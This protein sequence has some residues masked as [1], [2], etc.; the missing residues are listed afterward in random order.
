MINPKTYKESIKQVVD[1]TAGTS[2]IEMEELKDGR[3]LCL[4]FGYEEGY[5][6]G[7]DYQIRLG[8]SLLTL[9]AKLAVNIDDLQCDYDIDWRMPWDK[10][11]G[12]IC[13]TDMAVCKNDNFT[14]YEKEA[15][16]IKEGLD[17]GTLEVY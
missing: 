10:K 15:K 7:E 3:K 2:W 11:S 16:E 17:N 14:W 5:G 9:C 12:E 13:D 6:E 8:N 1:N 4:V